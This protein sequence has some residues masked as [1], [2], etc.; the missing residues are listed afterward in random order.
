MTSTPSP[1]SSAIRCWP[2]LGEAHC[3]HR[4]RS[5]DDIGSCRSTRR[6]QSKRP[7]TAAPCLHRQHQATDCPRPVS[8]GGGIGT[9]LRLCRCP[10]TIFALWSQSRIRRTPGI[11]GVLGGVLVSRRCP[12]WWAILK[13]HVCVALVPSRGDPGDRS[14]A[15]RGLISMTCRSGSRREA[16]GYPAGP[17]RITIVRIGS[18]CAASSLRLAMRSLTASSKFSSRMAKCVSY[19][20]ITDLRG[21]FHLC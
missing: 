2:L 12:H 15:L 7:K 19:R 6:R 3:L 5:H 13:L 18:S 16:C 20:S 4:Q 14:I 21:R 10:K 11:P 1:G 8:V 17:P 9:Q